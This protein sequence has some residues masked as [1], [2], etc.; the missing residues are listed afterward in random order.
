MKLLDSAKIKKIDKTKNGEKV[1][2]LQVVEEVYVQCNFADNK[3][4][5]KSEVL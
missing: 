5:Q 4:Q 1:S 3:Y 2:S